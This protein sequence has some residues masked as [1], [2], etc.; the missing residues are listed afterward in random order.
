[1]PILDREAT[2][3]SE[4]LSIVSELI[5][6]WSSPESGETKPWFRG[7][8]RADWNLV[9]GEYRFTDVDPDEI[10]SEFML[11]ARALLNDPPSTDWEWYFLM[12]H[13]GLP[14]RLLDW[15]AGSLIGLHFALCHDTGGSDAAVWVLDPWLLNKWSIGKSELVLTS[16]SIAD[17]YLCPPY[18]QKKASRRRRPIA[19]VPPYNSARITVQRGAFTVH[20]SNAKGI[21]QQFTTRLA[22]IQLPK[23]YCIQMRRELRYAGISEFTLFP[24]LDGLS[25]DIRAAEIEG[26]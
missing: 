11:K 13:H 21:D 26:C 15:T 22:K 18:Y 20:G 16:D 9:P 8:K 25:R 23:D 17:K 14:T 5:A 1:M 4:Y 19:V 12:Q 24:D 3:I 7:Q 6:D 2:S 10:R